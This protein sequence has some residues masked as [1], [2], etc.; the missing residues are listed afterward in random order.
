V[1]KVRR[2][3]IAVNRKGGVVVAGKNLREWRGEIDF[4]L[5]QRSKCTNRT[6]AK[7]ANFA[8]H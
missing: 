5:A 1:G 7:V 8:G 3:E 4:F 2:L 6:S